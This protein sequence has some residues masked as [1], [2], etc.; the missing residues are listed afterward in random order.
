[1]PPQRRA[2]VARETLFLVTLPSRL[3][4]PPSPTSSLHTLIRLSALKIKKGALLAYV[5]PQLLFGAS[6][7]L[8]TNKTLT[9]ALSKFDFRTGGALLSSANKKGVTLYSN[10]FLLGSK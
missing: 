7:P 5:L 10:I 9:P 8:D 2:S 6:V 3:H 1:M 4:L